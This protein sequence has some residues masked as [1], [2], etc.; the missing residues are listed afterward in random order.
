MDFYGLPIGIRPDGVSN[1][2]FTEYR[3]LGGRRVERDFRI[4]VRPDNLAAYLG[5]S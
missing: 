3:D 2:G 1:L 4:P 5:G